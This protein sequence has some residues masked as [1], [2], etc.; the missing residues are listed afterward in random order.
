LTYSKTSLRSHFSRSS[1]TK[2]KAGRSF[3]ASLIDEEQS[4][5]SQALSFRSPQEDSSD[6]EW[7]KMWKLA[8]MAAKM[9]LEK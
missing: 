1:H 2:S 6:I 5:T 3:P 7:G 9:Y 8:K 4:S